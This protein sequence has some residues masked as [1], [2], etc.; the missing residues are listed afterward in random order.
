MEDAEL[1]LPAPDSDELV[2]ILRYAEH[3]RIYRFLYERR[4]SPPTQVEISDYLVETT[5]R[6]ASQRGRRVRDLYPSFRIDKTPERVPR[7]ILKAR[8]VPVPPDKPIDRR[9]RAEVLRPQRCAMC[10]RTPLDDGVKLVVDHKLPR[11]WGGT[12]EPENLQPLCED[13]NAGKKD[14]FRSY[15]PFV[16]QIRQAATYDEPQRR[17]GELLLAFGTEEW[18][19]SDVIEI[20]ASAKEYQEDWHRRLRDL[21]YL[22]WEYTYKKKREGS[23]VRSYYRLVKFAPW[24]DDIAAVISAELNRRREARVKGS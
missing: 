22:G 6:A 4:N 13:C 2:G 17:I 5:G 12:N 9:T 16:A 1:P 19:R 20:V 21:R 15:E 23:R 3:R 11:D 14:H 18:V 7:Y 10:G 8:K 24:P